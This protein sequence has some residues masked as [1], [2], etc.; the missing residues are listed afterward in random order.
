MVTFQEDYSNYAFI[1]F[2]T[3]KSEPLEAFEVYVRYFETLSP[4]SK[5]VVRS[6]QNT[7]YTDMFKVVERLHT[8]H[9]NEYRTARKLLVNIFQTFSPTY[10]PKHNAIAEKINRTISDG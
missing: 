2:M 6:G 5:L 10:T 1:V 7:E 8:D 3:R 4:D 9:G